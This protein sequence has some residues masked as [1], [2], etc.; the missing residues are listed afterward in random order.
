MIRRVKQHMRQYVLHPA[1]PGFTF[2]VAVFDFIVERA[3]RELIPEP[4][5][6]L[7]IPP[8]SRRPV[9]CNPQWLPWAIRPCSGVASGCVR[10]R[11]SAPKECEPCVRRCRR[12]STRGPHRGQ[13]FAIRPVIVRKHA[14][15]IFG[16]H[17]NSLQQGVAGALR[18]AAQ[19]RYD[20]RLPDDKRWENGHGV[21][22]AANAESRTLARTIN[23]RPSYLRVQFRRLPEQRKSLGT[24]TSVR[25]LVVCRVLIFGY[26]YIPGAMAL[27]NA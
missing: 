10:A 2:A 12:T 1:G 8:T 9:P 13:A 27:V 23:C 16:V 5:Q 18:L 7:A 11:A 26:S 25:N 17:R 6:I 3:R 15:K 20:E 19:R 14:K 22:P 24:V 4:R 21:T